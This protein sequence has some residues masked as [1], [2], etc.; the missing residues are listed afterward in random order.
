MVKGRLFPV[1]GIVA[2]PARLAMPAGMD[3]AAGV[4]GRTVCSRLARFEIAE[5]TGFAGGVTVRACQRKV[6]PGGVIKNRLFPLLLRVALGTVL[7]VPAQVYVAQLVATEA[8]GCFKTVLLPR[9][10]TAAQQFF[11]FA[12]EREVGLTVIKS[13]RRVP[14][15]RGVTVFAFPAQPGPVRILFFVAGVALPGRIAKF[16]VAVR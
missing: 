2:L 12:L 9:V 14:V 3:I 10:T 15:I 6:C 13:G 1:A 8:I 7:A 16:L 4:A 5:M 11:V